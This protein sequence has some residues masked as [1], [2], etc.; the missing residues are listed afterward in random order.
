MN[1]AL[2]SKKIEGIRFCG[3]TKPQTSP[4]TTTRLHFMECRSIRGS[5]SRVCAKER[6][7]GG[8]NYCLAVASVSFSTLLRVKNPS[9]FPN[10]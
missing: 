2:T 8:K 6:K 9:K 3:K 10:R 5:M 7:F 1:L 4:D